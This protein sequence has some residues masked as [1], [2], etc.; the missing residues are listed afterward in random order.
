MKAIL[1][2]IALLGGYAS[3]AQ[4]AEELPQTCI[5]IRDGIKAVTGFVAVPNIDLI[6]QIGK[7]PECNFTSA[8]IYRA[9]RGDRPPPPQEAHDQ[10]RSRDQDDD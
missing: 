5:Q 2:V 1:I 8:E 9:A 4:A 7:H 10:N 3:A 6:Q